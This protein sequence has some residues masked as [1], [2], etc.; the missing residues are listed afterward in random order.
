MLLD[1]VKENEE[2]NEQID[3]LSSDL[4]KAHQEKKVLLVQKKEAEDELTR[5]KH[6][7]LAF[8]DIMANANRT[9]SRI[10]DDGEEN[11]LSAP[12]LSELANDL[13][14]FVRNLKK[15]LAQEQEKNSLLEE[16]VK[17]I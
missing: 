8:I 3:E 5:L 14:I 12:S 6:E 10:F 1:L 11:V 15:K 2:L 9:D 13:T 16:H 7:K 17:E 4:E